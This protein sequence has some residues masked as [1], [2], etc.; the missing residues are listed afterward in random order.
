MDGPEV[1]IFSKACVDNKIWGI[2]S[3]TGEENPVGNPSTR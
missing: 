2:V 1:E 3:L